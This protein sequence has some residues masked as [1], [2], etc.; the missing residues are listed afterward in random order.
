MGFH[1]PTLSY[2]H[3]SDNPSYQIIPIRAIKEIRVE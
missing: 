1:G 3:K 2:W